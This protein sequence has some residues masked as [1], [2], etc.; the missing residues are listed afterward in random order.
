MWLFVLSDKRIEASSWQLIDVKSCFSIL[1]KKERNF[2]SDV[3]TRFAWV[4]EDEY[5]LQ[6]K[7]Q[8]YLIINKRVLLFELSPQ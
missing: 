1:V 8:N 7:H 4:V 2:T 5:R 3:V 6:K